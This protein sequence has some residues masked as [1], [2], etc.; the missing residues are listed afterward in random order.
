LGAP[1]K[2]LLMQLRIRKRIPPVSTIITMMAIS[3]G[4]GIVFMPVKLRKK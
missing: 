2:P 4:L 1:P 3:Q